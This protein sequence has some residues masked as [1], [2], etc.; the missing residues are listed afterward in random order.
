MD[1]YNDLRIEKKC[2]RNKISFLFIRFFA[3]LCDITDI[4]VKYYYK[5]IK[6]LDTTTFTKILL[7]IKIPYLIKPIYGLLIDFV[8]IFGYK[9]RIYLFLCFI[10]N[11]LS[12]YIFIFTNDIGLYTSIFCILLV[13]ITISF[14]TVIGSA[15]QV[16]IYKLQDSQNNISKGT[17]DLMSKSF[18]IKSIGSLVPC[19]F[20]GFLIE[21]YSQDIIF[22]MSGIISIFILISGL[23][24]DEDR[25]QK[26]K[27]TKSQKK[28]VDF[29]PLIAPKKKSLSSNKITNLVQNRNIII[30]MLLI[31]ILESS[32]SCVSPLFYY[33]TN[34]LGLNPKQLGLMDFS[35]Q[36]SI[37]LV[38]KVYTKFFYKY[39]FKSLTFFV[40]ILVFGSFSLIYMLIMKTTQEYIND[41]ILLVFAISI[42]AGLHSL[43]QL[44]YSLLCMKYAPFG[45]EATTYSFCVFSC[46]LGNIFA[47]YLDY[48]LSLYFKVTHY[49]FV[50]LGKLV[51]VENIL[52]LI[53]LLYIWIIPKKFFSAKKRVS[54]TTEL[55][56]LEKKKNGDNE[57]N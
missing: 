57:N 31:F 35:S 11:L 27:K 50:N 34:I 5:D 30:L 37:I 53:P 17:T 44:P 46:Y 22:Y 18:I 26:I 8:P 52:N 41:F 48:L 12:W 2:Q 32:P 28:L 43:G 56:D 51:F 24:L 9:K 42:N 13:N 21:K 49:D 33:E 15:I 6:E 1:D 7:V 4:G 19:Y 47:D 55:K 14:T 3:G 36:I 39:N 25:V 45:L 16:E 54:S 10:I 23:I 40:R 38:I 29:S 20:K